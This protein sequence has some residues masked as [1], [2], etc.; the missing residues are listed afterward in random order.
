MDNAKHGKFL[1]WTTSYG[2]LLVVSFALVLPLR[3]TFEL[4]MAVMAVAGLWLLISQTRAVMAAPA[5]KPFLVMGACLWLPMLASLPDA[6]NFSRA[7][8][9]TLVFLRFPLAAIFVMFAL[10]TADSRRHLLLWL[11]WA[12]SLN[13]VCVVIQALLEHAGLAGGP[14]LFSGLR[15]LGFA[16]A[17]LSPV[18]LYWLWRVAQ[19]WRWIWLLLPVYLVD[20]FLCGRRAAWIMLAVGI[21]LWV[22]Q[23]IRVEKVQWRWKSMAALVLS[24]ALAIGAAMQLPELSVRVSQTAGL[25]SGN[26]EQTNNATSLRL[27]IWKVAVRVARDHWINGIG[28]RGFRYIY[29]QYGE[30]DDPFLA[31]NPKVGPTHPHQLLLEIATETGLIG[32]VGYLIA[33]VY[34]LRLALAA[35]REKMHQ[36]LPFMA[37]VLIAIMPINAHMAFY[38]SFWSCITWWLIMLSLAFWQPSRDARA[39]SA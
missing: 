9:T 19:Q 23:L 37:A 14:N 6:V 2:W 17:V 13:A 33:L 4:P 30:K 28:P 3:H 16:M 27:P 24:C 35:A 34:W 20:V 1:H 21:A 22:V 15:G 31:D 38:A 26:Y 7:M 39:E 25:F 32:V 36:A 18:Y 29:K 8:Y 11:G 10:Q 12:M 5:G